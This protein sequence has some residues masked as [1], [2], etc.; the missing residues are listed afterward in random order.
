MKRCSRCGEENKDENRF[1]HNCG[2]K[3]DSF[4][5]EIAK[6]DNIIDRFRNAHILIRIIII[7]ILVFVLMVAM[8]WAAHLLFGIPLEYNTEADPTD[9]PDDFNN[10]D[11][12]G[13]GALSLYEVSVLAPDISS[14][15]LQKIF[16]SADKSDDGLLKGAEFDGYINGINRHYKNLEKQKTASGENDDSSSKGT[17]SKSLN[18]VEACPEC[19]SEEIILYPSSDEILYQ[20]SECGYESY[21]SDEFVVEVSGFIM[22]AVGL[23]SVL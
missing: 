10:L 5:P 3:L 22:P 11:S 7:I 23:N 12:D 16:D 15:K 4:K 14:E 1:C 20:C 18:Y 2:A 19:G 21:D 9:F 13:D 17:G 6:N 8:A